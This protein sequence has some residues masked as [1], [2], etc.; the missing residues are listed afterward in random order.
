MKRV[1]VAS[2]QENLLS[3]ITL[4]LK[5]WGYRT[6]GSCKSEELHELVDTVAPQLV[7]LDDA[8]LTQQSPDVRSALLAHLNT[9]T[10]HLA[11]ITAADSP[12]AEISR[13]HHILPSPVNIFS[14]YSLTQTLLEDYPR[15]NFRTSINLPVMFR[16][17]SRSWEL[18]RIDTL[19]TGGM[20]IKT[21][22]RLQAGEVLGLCVPL[23]GM[24]EELEMIGQVVYAVEPCPEN[25]YMQGYGISFSGMEGNSTSA[26][27]DFLEDLFF[28]RV[29]KAD[30]NR[31]S[32]D[33][34]D[35]RRQT[36]RQAAL[37]A[38][39]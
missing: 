24:H 3:T 4:V 12:L 25:N 23:L 34:T 2:C 26:L 5:Q 20:F 9:N 13:A 28:M 8:W 21:G 30:G 35:L 19:G 37:S 7:V 32:F 15:R 27:N 14:L 22:H 29:D 17:Q 18:A 1:L 39:I 31:E 36:R 16:R 38:H 33:P 6:I 10:A 11:L